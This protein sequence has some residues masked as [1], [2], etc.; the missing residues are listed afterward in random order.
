MTDPHPK[1][2]VPQVIRRSKRKASVFASSP[3]FIRR[4]NRCKQYQL[5]DEKVYGQDYGILPSD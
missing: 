5:E 3:E 4:S 1:D 2:I